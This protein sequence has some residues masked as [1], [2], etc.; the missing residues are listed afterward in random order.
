MSNSLYRI[1]DPVALDRIRKSMIEIS[2]SMTREG[3]EKDL[4]NEIATTVCKEFNLN[5][6][7]FK[8]AAKAFHK[9]NFREEK[10]LNELFETLYT[11]TTGEEVE[12]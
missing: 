11:Q 1:T 5:R 4:I 8:R 6:K 10:E 2:N 3:A 12:S 9:Q 7:A